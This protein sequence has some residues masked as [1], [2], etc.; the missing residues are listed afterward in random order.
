MEPLSPD[1]RRFVMSVRRLP[2]AQRQF[3]VYG[4]TFLSDGI[5]QIVRQAERDQRRAAGRREQRGG[6]RR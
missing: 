3:F 4:L 5:E 6:K 1:L 2:R